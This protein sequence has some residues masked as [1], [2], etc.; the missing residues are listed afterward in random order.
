MAGKLQ[1]ADFLTALQITGAGGTIS[2]LLNT[3]KIYDDVHSQLLDTT[4]ASIGSSWL[5]AGNA[6]TGGTGTLG[7]TDAQPWTTLVNGLTVD[8]Y[9][10]DASVSSILNVTPVDASNFNQKS[11]QVNLIPTGNT[12]TANFSNKINFVDYDG[13]NTG[14]DFGGSLLS[15]SNRVQHSGA[16]TVA[17]VSPNDNSAFFAAVA[18]TTSLFKG[19]NLDTQVHAGYTMTNYLGVN[20]YLSY[21][22]AIGDGISLYDSNANIL[23]STINNATVVASNMLFQGSTAV[24]GNA[25]GA[26]W[27][28]NFQ[29][30]ASTNNAF[31]Y[32]AGISFSDTASATGQVVGNNV[33]L[34]FSDNAQATAANITLE[35]P[36]LDVRDSADVGNVTGLN[37]N[38]QVRNTATA[39]GITGLNV[40]FST[41]DTATVANYS[42]TNINP[43]ISGSSVVGFLNVLSTG[44]NV[45][46][47]AT[48]TNNYNGAVINPVIQGTATANSMTGLQVGAS[49]QGTAVVTTNITGAS[50]N[51][52]TATPQ[53]AITG[54][55]VDVGGAS[56]TAAQ[57]L[58]GAQKIGIQVNDGVFST[59]YNYIVP[60]PA[61][62]FQDNYIGGS[63]TVA[64]AAPTAAFGF[65][66]NMAQSVVL[67]DD[68]TID[69]AGLGFVNVGF[70]SSLGFDAGTT[71]ARWTGALGGA[72][73]PAGA[74]TLTDAICFRAAGI[75]N[76]GGT[77][78]VTNSYGFQVDPVF[79]GSTGVNSWGFFE[80]TTVAENHLSKLAISTSTKKVANISTAIEIGNSTAFLNGRGN[81]ATKNAL[82]ALAG[83]QFYDTTLDLLEWY[84][85][86][87]WVSAAGG[88]SGTV[89]S[90]VAGR[91]A[92]YPATS[93]LVNDQYPQTG[94]N[95]DVFIANQAL[96]ADREYTIDDVGA[97]ASFVMTVGA[98]AI[99]GIKT[100]SATP[101][102]KTALDFEDPGAGTNKITMIAP[103]PLAASYT[104]T[105]PPDDGNFGEFLTTDG[106]G[107]TSWASPSG[108]G[109]VNSGVAGRLALYPATGT[110]V[111]DQ[112][113]QTGFNVDIFIAN[114]ALGADRQYTIP[115]S[116]TD[117]N[118]VMAEGAQTINA[119]KT[120]SSAPLLKAGA[121]YEDP[122]AGTNKITLIAP[123]PLAASYTFTLPPDD[124]SA[125]QFLQTDGAGLTTWATVSGTPA[126][127]DAHIFVGN[128]GNVATDVAVS[129][130]LSLVNTGA[131]TVQKA[132]DSIF[133]IYNNADNTK[134]FNWDLSS[135]T[136]ATTA[137][138]TPLATQNQVYQ[139]QPNVDATANIITQNT[140][141]G[142]IFIGANST[143]GG[144]NS[145][146]QYSD[147]TTANRGQIKLG[148]YVNAASIAGVSTLTS[149]SGTV[150]VNASIAS[151]QDYSKW[152][153]QA[154]A[155]TAGSAP[156]SGTFA[157]KANSI[158]AL[159][160]PSDYHIQLTNLAG[161]LG[162]RLYLSSEG[163]L[164]LPGYTT[165]IAHFDASGNITSSAVDLTTDVTGVLPVL[166][167]GTGQSSYTNGQLLIGNT[168]GNTLTKTTLT[169]GAN[170]TITN[171]AGSITIASTGGAGAGNDF[172][173]CYDAN[174]FASTN[175]R[176]VYY[177]ST[178][179]SGASVTPAN[180][181]VNGS[182]LT[183][184]ATGMY[185]VS[186]NMRIS[187]TGEDWVLLLNA[188]T[189]TDFTA[190]PAG[191]ETITY[192][193]LTNAHNQASRVVYLNSG[194][195]IR[196][197]TFSGGTI[198]G[199]GPQYIAATRVS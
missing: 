84:D 131:F 166:N 165:G 63:V 130:D 186:G 189:I 1:N 110:T 16:G 148:S 29:D 106:A 76:Q 184:N 39:Q 24:A 194:D 190:Y 112:Y 41:N 61:A 12:T 97:S 127:T 75:L 49:V 32:A 82:T 146:I 101:L 157:F 102:L 28:I 83:M 161:T 133:F 180:D 154:A 58:T 45:N 144:S 33:N 182:S 15:V 160:V 181:S 71:M 34:Q 74:G 57:L 126:L 51:V 44:G 114:Q 67:H 150:G 27:N 92:L 87:T 116:G 145:G 72:G 155:A 10:I 65:G 122:G 60:G 179:S 138:I 9:A 147:A 96:G 68:W 26:S 124:G 5:L 3:A 2:Q 18:G 128:A 53:F 8:T 192:S 50:V 172:G 98:Q 81:T 52:N 23:D 107:V 100:F 109:T 115:D 134:K 141:S 36:G 94:F 121:D 91:L 113:A 88:G 198:V 37:Q 135:L 54:L 168:T 90:G 7:T 89:S 62:F 77:L 151:G 108:S 11:N 22:T 142:Q 152:T 30:T 191:T 85:G 79:F 38:I 13:G 176:I 187:G 103:T 143:I 6:G 20:S 56:L 111:D 164:Q 139:I 119:I 159:T 25:Q 14:F 123:T 163:L 78:A 162:D 185:E 31:G 170:I 69:A 19:V 104:F 136:T 169:A 171:G 183:I 42:G 132:N 149:K 105:L 4:L 43:N 70:V 64:A 173:M 120:F 80:D 188:V 73:N 156:I 177:N 99:A 55:N 35:Q 47:A 175:T 167:G 46:G 137:T 140:T 158:N 197:A 118:F 178:T 117:A 196:N 193:T 195:V 66:T 125:G 21:D 129:G 174:A 93:N 153:A 59:G 86:T 199:G 17:Y 40:G 95:V 48:I